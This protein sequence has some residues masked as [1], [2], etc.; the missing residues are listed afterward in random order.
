MV[1]RNLKSQQQQLH[2]TEQ[3][4]L[5]IFIAVVHAT[6]YYKSLSYVRGKS[7]I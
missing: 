2:L 4:E 7:N 5:L 1:K 3:L 6:I